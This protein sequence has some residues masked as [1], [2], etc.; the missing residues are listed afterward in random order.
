LRRDGGHDYSSTR[1]ESFFED[2]AL[3]DALW[4]GVVKGE[5]QLN[6][7]ATNHWM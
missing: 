2:E 6:N 4:P 1:L 5:L 7:A 3:E